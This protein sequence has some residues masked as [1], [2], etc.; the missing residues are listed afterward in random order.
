M[1]SDI[2]NMRTEGLTAV[3]S[4]KRFIH[5]LYKD[6]E[7]VKLESF[8][9]FKEGW[10]IVLSWAESPGKARQIKSFRLQEDGRVVG[11]KTIENRR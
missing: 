3:K 5:E 1:G 8:L 7:D 2:I 4:A 10:E 9:Q 11:M 6:I